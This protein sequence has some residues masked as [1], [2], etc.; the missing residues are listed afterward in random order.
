MKHFEI[1]GYLHASLNN[2]KKQ[3][4]L[5]FIICANTLYVKILFQQ[6]RGE[7][8][9]TVSKYIFHA[10]KHKNKGKRKNF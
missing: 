8:V 1:L 2:F 9:K 4:R 3:Y 10:H 6:G 5:P 7:V